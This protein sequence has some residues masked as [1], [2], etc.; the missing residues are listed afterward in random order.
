[1]IRVCIVSCLLLVPASAS[2]QGSFGPGDSEAPTVE[3]VR[4]AILIGINQYD[5]E[6]FSPLAYARNDAEGLGRVLADSAYGGFDTVDLIV[7]GNL[8]ARPIVDALTEWSKTLAPEDQALIY[9]SGHGTRFVDERNRSRVFLAAADTR[10]DDPVHTGIALDALQELLESLPARRRILI[11]DACFTG[12]GKTTQDDAA[13]AARSMIDE[14]LPFSDRAAENEARL[15]A[16]TYGRPAL[17]SD[18]LGHGVYTAHLIEALSERFDD[19]DLN[20]DRVVSVSEAHDY[21]RDRTM[22]TT[23]QLQVPMVFYKIVGYEDL[24]LSGD[25]HSRVRVEM[26]MVSSYAGP[27][28]GLRM[29]V[30]GQEK[31][32]FPR[33]VLVEPGPRQV[34]FKTLDGKTVDRGRVVFRKSGIYSVTSIRDS[35]NGGRHLLSFGYA[36]SFIRGALQEGDSP[37]PQA[38]GF[39]FAYSFRFPSRVPLLRRLGL[40]FDVVVGGVPQQ[41]TEPLGSSPQTTLVDLGIGPILRLDLPYVVLSIQPRFAVVNLLRNHV[42]EDSGWV[43]WTFGTIGSNFAVGFRPVNRFSIQFQYLIAG[44]NAPLQDDGVKIQLLHRLIGTVEVGF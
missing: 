44:Y 42:G 20:G 3:G 28:Q 39:R 19:A 22:E 27:Q 24:L 33:T 13:A 38:P 37:V 29:F 4:K 25:P 9:F 34:E 35:L 6:S 15:F 30:D 11:V 2:A 16:T 8:G 32:A 40:V 41:E 43:N 31:G 10:R 23:G 21:A 26:A 18:E 5:D 14:K 12:D 1:M 36:H 7:S 17:E